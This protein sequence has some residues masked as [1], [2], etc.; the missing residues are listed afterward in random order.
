MNY[1]L[2]TSNHLQLHYLES[3][4]YKNIK[5]DDKYELNS[6]TIFFN[7]ESTYEEIKTILYNN[8][9]MVNELFLQPVEIEMK[10]LFTSGIKDF[11]WANTKQ[12]FSLKLTKK[13]IYKKIEEFGIDSITD[14][15]SAILQDEKVKE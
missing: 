9:N 15:E 5:I 14:E 8:N 1:I 3:I 6:S 12:N 10:A 2:I 4:L 13:E 11:L 7:T